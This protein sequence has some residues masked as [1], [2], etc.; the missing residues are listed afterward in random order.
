MKANSAFEA[1]LRQISL[2]ANKKFKKAVKISKI[3]GEN[4]IDTEEYF[5]YKNN[6]G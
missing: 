3:T 4:Y 6:K 2:D 5:K 1:K